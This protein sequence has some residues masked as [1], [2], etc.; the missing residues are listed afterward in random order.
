MIESTTIDVQVANPR[1]WSEHPGLTHAHRPDGMTIGVITPLEGFDGPVPGIDNHIGLI[2]QAER[3]GF[4]SVWVRDVPLLD[5][6]F[7]DTGQVFDTW[8]YLGYL[9]ATTERISLGTASVVLPLRHPLDTAK[10]ASSIDHLSGGRLL[11]GVATGDRAVEFPAYGVGYESR[12]E[13]FK[14]SLSCCAK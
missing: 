14:E 13:R 10:A 1:P 4:S 3:A 9:A 11:L 5:P 8:S 12:G 2:Q 7:G 6:S